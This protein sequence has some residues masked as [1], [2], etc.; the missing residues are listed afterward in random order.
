MFMTDMNFCMP[1]NHRNKYKEKMKI[2]TLILIW[3]VLKIMII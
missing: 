3:K 1:N 2:M